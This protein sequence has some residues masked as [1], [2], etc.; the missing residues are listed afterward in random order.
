MPGRAYYRLRQVDLDG[1]V[2]YSN[3]A[4]L[5]AEDADDGVQVFPSPFHHTLSV[6]LPLATAEQVTLSLVDARGVEVYRHSVQLLPGQLRGLHTDGLPVG[7][8]HLRVQPRHS[9]HHTQTVLKQ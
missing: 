4:I 1:A 5:S 8:Y 7:I 9:P 3:V 2:A 6:M